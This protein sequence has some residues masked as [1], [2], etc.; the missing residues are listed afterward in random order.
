MADEPRSV[1]A[2]RPA[3][4]ILLLRD[5]PLEVLMVRRNDAAFFASALVF[6]GGL[7]EAEDGSEAWLPHVTGGEG[8]NAEERALRIAAI[9]ETFEEAAILIADDVADRHLPAAAADA[10]AF[11]AL[12]AGSGGRLDLSRVQHFGHWV[13]PEGSPKR[14]DTHFFLARAPAGQEAICDGG[15]TVS[16]EWVRPVDALARADAG[17]RSILFPTR[18]NL[19]RLAESPDVDHAIAAAAARPRFTVRPRVEK[20]PDGMAVIIPEEAGYGVTEDFHPRPPK[21]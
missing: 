13:T 6:P 16:L 7:V 18:M 17:E 2:A 15:E 8:L 5:D 3:A 20:R 4:T 19:R 1:S 14:F 10:A 9:R 21:R 11:R 12:V